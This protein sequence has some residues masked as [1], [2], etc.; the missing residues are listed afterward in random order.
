MA[1]LTVEQF[2]SLQRGDLFET[3]TPFAGLSPE[4]FVFQVEE[5]KELRNTRSIWLRCSYLGVYLCDYRLT[6]D[7]AG[8]EIVWEQGM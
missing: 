8:K 7:L 1:N 2:R 5:T 6:L 4:P 3:G